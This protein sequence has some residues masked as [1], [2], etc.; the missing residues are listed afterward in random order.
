LIGVASLPTF[1]QADIRHTEIFCHSFDFVFR[2][3]GAKSVYPTH[4][5]A[6]GFQRG[7][8]RAQKRGQTAAD[9]SI[10][11]WRWRTMTIDHFDRFANGRVK[12]MANE[13]R[14]Q[15]SA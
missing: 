4:T 6:Q 8:C 3:C 7:F 15:L 2:S 11:E 1:L 14:R 12:A 10:F 5:I 9:A 13:E